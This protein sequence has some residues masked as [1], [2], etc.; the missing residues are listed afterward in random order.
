LVNAWTGISACNIPPREY[1][2]KFVPQG[3]TTPLEISKNKKEMVG[4]RHNYEFRKFKNAIQT[5]K[6]TK[7]SIVTI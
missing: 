4:V 1:N 7:I 6:Q 5:S 2:R 3:T